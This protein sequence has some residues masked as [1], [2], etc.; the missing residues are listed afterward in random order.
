VR[1]KRVRLPTERLMFI[2]KRSSLEDI[3]RFVF[4]EAQQ[5]AIWGNVYHEWNQDPGD[6]LKKCWLLGYAPP[7]PP[8]GKLPPFGAIAPK[9]KGDQEISPKQHSLEWPISGR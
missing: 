1:T 4:A 3:E 7:D 9:P 2:D 8:C 5:L 6:D